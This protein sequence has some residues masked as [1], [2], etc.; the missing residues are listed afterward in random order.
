MLHG[1]TCQC[2]TWFSLFTCVII[3][4]TLER[5]F[6]CAC[7]FIKAHA[8]KDRGCKDKTT[9]YR[10]AQIKLSFCPY[11]CP[12]HGFLSVTHKVSS[13]DEQRHHPS[14]VFIPPKMG[15]QSLNIGVVLR[16]YTHSDRHHRFFN[17][18][19]YDD[20]AG[21]PIANF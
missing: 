3:F 10:R 17:V 8:L 11:L 16:R 2:K 6:Q 21:I 13:K 14:P 20:D 7:R 9:I 18:S 12:G 19:F 5:L 4:F 15:L 1:A